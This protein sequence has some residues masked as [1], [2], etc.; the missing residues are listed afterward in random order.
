MPPQPAN[1]LELSEWFSLVGGWTLPQRTE[2]D[3][4]LLNNTIIMV[5][6]SKLNIREKIREYD[7]YIQFFYIL[8]TF[9]LIFFFSFLLLSLELRVAVVDG[10]LSEC[11]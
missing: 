2:T 6:L 1:Q 9:C 8:Y 5:L 10:P 3:A 7:V 11:T 4:Y